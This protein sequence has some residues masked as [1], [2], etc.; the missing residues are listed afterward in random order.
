M[1]DKKNVLKLKCK[2]CENTFKSQTSR[3]NH[4]KKFHRE[5]HNLLK[6]LR[7]PALFNCEKCSAK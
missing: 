7:G 1:A 6:G 3:S 2:Y 5:K 4:H